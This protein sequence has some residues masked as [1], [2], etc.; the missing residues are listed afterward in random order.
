MIVKQ[1]TMPLIILSKNP[2]KNKIL[3]IFLYRIDILESFFYAKVVRS[4]FFQFERVS[5]V[6]VIPIQFTPILT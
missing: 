3:Q 5:F 4:D 1:I 6:S 2:G